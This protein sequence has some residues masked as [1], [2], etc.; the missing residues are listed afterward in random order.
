MRPGGSSMLAAKSLSR[1]V[2]RLRLRLGLTLGLTLALG[3]LA[4]GCAPRLARPVDPVPPPAAEPSG[5]SRFITDLELL[6]FESLADYDFAPHAFVDWV[7]RLGARVD[8]QLAGDPADR[9]VLIQVTMHKDRDA[10]L[11]I[12]ASPPLAELRRSALTADLLQSR[13]PRTEL[14][15]YSVRFVATVGRGAPDRDASCTPPLERP[16]TALVQRLRAASLKERVALLS[17]W[18]RR[19]VLPVLARVMQGAPERFPGVRSVG[20]L[21]GGLDMSRVVAVPEA[22]DHNPQYWRALTEVQTGNPLVPAARIFL[23]VANGELDTARLYL[24]PVYFF[25]KADNLAHDYIELFKELI[26][27]FQADLEERINRGVELH[28]RGEYQEAINIYEAVLSEYPCSSLALYEKFFSGALLA[29]RQQSPDAA[30][31]APDRELA[32]KWQSYRPRVYACNPM[33]TMDARAG[34]KRESFQAA[35]RHSIRGLFKR[36]RDS[37]GDWVKMAD[38]ALDIEEFG[39]S[40]HLYYLINSVMDPAQFSNRNLISY[41]LYC[42]EKLGVTTLKAEWKGDHEREFERISDEREQLL[43]TG[44]A[45][46]PANRPGI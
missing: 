14:T 25:S 7:K 18:S 2:F 34:T 22:L 36:E 46:A 6:S 4:G 37:A 38:I 39:F 45:P 29:G 41:W 27:I 9:T 16:L 30:P 1:L 3:L 13:P 19:D 20:Q 31:A 43:Q 33:F 23:H 35:R 11:V 42:L 24:K 10:E 28:D 17:A 40:A 32:A 21:L 15:D 8:A 12:A 44:L 26:V 5:K